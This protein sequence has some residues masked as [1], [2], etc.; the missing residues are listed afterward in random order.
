V[1]FFF[2]QWGEIKFF[3]VGAEPDIHYSSKEIDTLDS[4]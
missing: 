4:N 3:E 2:K 1:P